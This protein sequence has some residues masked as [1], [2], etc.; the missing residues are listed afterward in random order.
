MKMREEGKNRTSYFLLGDPT[1]F[2]RTVLVTFALSFS[3][4]GTTGLLSCFSVSADSLCPAPPPADGAHISQELLPTFCC[5]STSV[6]GGTAFL[7]ESADLPTAVLVD[8]MALSCSH[9]I[10]CW[11]AGK[12]ALCPKIRQA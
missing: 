9:Q 11:L 12:I 5:P 8:G 10:P 6:G 3:M 2:I 1:F 7:A 4:V